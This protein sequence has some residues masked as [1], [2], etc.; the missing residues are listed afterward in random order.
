MVGNLFLSAR[1][2]DRLNPPMKIPVF[3]DSCLQGSSKTELSMRCKINFK[4]SGV[5]VVPL[6]PKEQPLDVLS[7]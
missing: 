7:V 5:K 2:S 3:H 1:R 4:S 6:Y